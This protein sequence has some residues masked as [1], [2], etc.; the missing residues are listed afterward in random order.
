MTIEN[1]IEVFVNNYL[2]SGDS[3]KA[4]KD[5]SSNLRRMLL[6]FAEEFFRMETE[7][8]AFV[9][10]WFPDTTETLITNWESAVGIP[11]SCF[12]IGATLQERRNNVILKL[13]SLGIQTSS[14]FEIFAERIGQDIKVRSGIDHV[15]VNQGGYGT[16]DPKLSIDNAVILSDSNATIA[17][18]TV[19]DY[20]ITSFATPPDFSLI[21][22]GMKC[23]VINTTSG[24]GGNFIVHSFNTAPG[25]EA[26]YITINDTLPPNPTN[27]T[28]VNEGY[29][30][31]SRG[32][33]IATRARQTIVVTQLETQ[34][35]FDY[36]FD[37]PFQDAGAALLRCVLRKAKPA[38]CDIL[39]TGL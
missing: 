5:E 7:I 33:G 23:L 21:Y 12:P 11:D 32:F 19:A 9:N 4:A 22:V 20:E 3:F 26:I 25:S 1:N 35:S 15:P 10:E 29:V 31:A 2:P 13:S 28:G 36:T 17:T 14:D 39:F 16:E 18:S 38:H 24:V 8:A 34:N 27:F 6:G 37:F 30:L